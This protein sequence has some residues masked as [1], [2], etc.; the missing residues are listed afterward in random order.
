MSEAEGDFIV[1]LSFTIAYTLLVVIANIYAWGA[2]F[3]VI[4]KKGK[5]DE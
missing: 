4:K 5:K 3:Q 2:F 1:C